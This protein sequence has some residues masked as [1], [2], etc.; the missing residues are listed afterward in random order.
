MKKD[1]FPFRFA[2]KF[3]SFFQLWSRGSPEKRATGP[4]TP[5]IDLESSKSGQAFTESSK[6]HENRTSPFLYLTHIGKLHDPGPR[7]AEHAIHC[8]ATLYVLQSIAQIACIDPVVSRSVLLIYRTR[9]V[10]YI[11]LKLLAHQYECSED[12]PSIK[13]TPLGFPRSHQL[14]EIW[15][16]HV[17]GWKVGE[18]DYK[19]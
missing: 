9:S 4:W 19:H 13:L 15:F 1:P 12:L 11:W 6:P 10:Q 16:M 7:E 14:K 5:H 17:C 18:R 8:H 2:F 3:L